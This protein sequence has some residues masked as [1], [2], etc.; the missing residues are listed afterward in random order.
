MLSICMLKL[1]HETIYQL[2]NLLFKSCLETG[3]PLPEWKKA[4][5]A[6]AFK[7][8][9]KQLL[10]S[11]CPIYLLPI[12]GKVLERFLYNQMFEFFIRNKLI[13]QNQPG[14]K[15]GDFCIKTNLGTKIFFRS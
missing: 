11:N 3:Q 5:V 12:T 10:K 6:P 1:C 2:L 9:S 14:F 15:S 4:N 7:T 13:S 8:G